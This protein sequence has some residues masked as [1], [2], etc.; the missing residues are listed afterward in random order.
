M[1]C[2]SG[3][4]QQHAGKGVKVTTAELDL[5]VTLPLLSPKGSI[6]NHNKA[7]VQFIRTLVY[8]LLQSKCPQFSERTEAMFLVLFLCLGF[9][10]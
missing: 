7:Q 9:F 2:C 10:V 6:I 3:G 4:T 5:V 1:Q 8:S